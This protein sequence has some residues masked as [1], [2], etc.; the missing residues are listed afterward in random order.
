MMT[1]ALSESASSSHT[2]SDFLQLSE[3]SATLALPPNGQ[4]KDISASA[5]VFLDAPTYMKS[6]YPRKAKRDTATVYE[7]PLHK[8]KDNL[9]KVQRQSFPNLVNLVGYF[10]SEGTEA[11][12]PHLHEH[13]MFEEEFQSITAT[14]AFQHLSF[15]ELRLVDYSKGQVYGMF[16]RKKDRKDFSAVLHPVVQQ[17]ERQFHALS[18]GFP[19]TKDKA[20]LHQCMDYIQ[21]AWDHSKQIETKL[22]Y[23]PG[24]L[25]KSFVHIGKARGDVWGKREQTDRCYS[26]QTPT[27]FFLE[28]LLQVIGPYLTVSEQ[29]QVKYDLGMVQIVSVNVQEDPLFEI[30]KLEFESWYIEHNEYIFR[31][32]NGQSDTWNLEST[33]QNIFCT[34]EYNV[35]KPDVLHLFQQYSLLER[36][37]KFTNGN[38]LKKPSPRSFVRSNSNHYRDLLCYR[39]TFGPQRCRVLELPAELRVQIL[40]DLLLPVTDR[41]VSVYDKGILHP[42]ILRTCKQIYDE[43]LPIYLRNTFRFPLRRVWHRLIP[44]LDTLPL[45]TGTHRP[46]IRHIE[47]EVQAVNWRPLIEINEE[48]TENVH[49]YSELIYC[50]SN[51]PG[52]PTVPGG[53]WR[54]MVYFVTPDDFLKIARY[55]SLQRR[56][57]NGVEAGYMEHD[58]RSVFKEWDRLGLGTVETLTL[59]IH[60]IDRWMFDTEFVNYA[61]GPGS[62]KFRNYPVLALLASI[63]LARP[64]TKSIIFKGLGRARQEIESR[65]REIL[66]GEIT[67]QTKEFLY[68]L[69]V[70]TSIHPYKIYSQI[71]DATNQRPSREERSW[72]NLDVGILRNVAVTGG[73]YTWEFRS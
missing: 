23:S 66:D 59:D 12:V 47:F 26:E 33:Q 60:G 9:A 63:I 36:G 37:P 49:S 18:L 35:W 39:F 46:N 72:G 73:E 61:N 64:K 3:L 40:E 5:S 15:E 32:R 55:R 10:V 2:D 13:E 54:N 20:L 43:G 28:C 16:G 42:A 25:G 71:W 21:D 68:S 29:G 58:M 1:S 51:S 45:I 48:E 30:M 8:S 31:D 17:I 14:I 62:Q 65:W 11:I 52:R 67:G 41:S 19:I 44:Y 56:I 69:Q 70:W 38:L 4:R 50:L 6:R 24:K 7:V 22:K 57:P 34:I 53:R 27:A